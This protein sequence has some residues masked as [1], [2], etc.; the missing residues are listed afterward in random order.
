MCYFASR[1]SISEWVSIGIK[2]T[3]NSPL[4]PDGIA[5]DIPPRLGIVIPHVVVVQSGLGIVIL[6]GK[7][8]GFRS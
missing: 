7:Y 1:I 4:Q 8:Y 2:I 6:A 3:I 5:L